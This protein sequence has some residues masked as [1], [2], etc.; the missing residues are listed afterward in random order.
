MD[1]NLAGGWATVSGLILEVLTLVWVFAKFVS[2]I[3]NKLDAID[4]EQK[5][6]HG[7]SMR[8]AINRIEE[9]VKDIQHDVHTIDNKLAKLEGKFE[10]HVE[11]RYSA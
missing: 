5:P 2:K 7:S 9:T 11:E 8:D 4:A 1:W 10:Q 6:N 3:Q